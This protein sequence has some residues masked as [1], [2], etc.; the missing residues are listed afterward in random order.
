VREVGQQ[1]KRARPEAEEWGSVP[2]THTAGRLLQS[3]GH[4]DTQSKTHAHTISGKL[5]AIKHL[6]ARKDG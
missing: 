5:N 4:C 6:K 3:S 2:E 1:T